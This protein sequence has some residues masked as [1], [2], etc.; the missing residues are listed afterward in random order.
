MLLEVKNLNVVLDGEKIIEDLSFRVDRGDILTILGP[1]GAG[2]SVLLKTI[3]G[4]FPYSGEIVWHQKP[5]IGYV[6][7]GLSQL[8]VKDFPLTIQDFFALKD[9]TPTPTEIA[10]FLQFVGLDKD[11]LS[12]TASHLSGGQFQRMLIAWA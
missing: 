3:L 7:Q 12:K 5:K 8:S 6:P 1:N 10:H 2:K 9:P 4:F 11:I